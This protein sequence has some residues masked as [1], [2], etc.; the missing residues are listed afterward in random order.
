MSK[1]KKRKRGLKA[2]SLVSKLGLQMTPE[3]ALAIRVG[4]LRKPRVR[5][6]STTK[7]LLPLPEMT[8]QILL[9]QQGEFHHLVH[10]FALFRM[11]DGEL[12]M[13]SRK[14]VYPVYNSGEYLFVDVP[15][16]RVPKKDCSPLGPIA[17]SSERIR[18]ISSPSLLT[19]VEKLSEHADGPKLKKLALNIKNSPAAVA[20]KPRAA[21]SAMTYAARWLRQLNLSQNQ[22]ASDDVRKRALSQLAKIEEEIASLDDQFKW[23]STEAPTGSG[24][25]RSFDAPTDGILSL[26]GYQVGHASQLN[27]PTRYLILDR[28]FRMS[29]PPVL[30]GSHMALWGM[31][32]SSRRL[33]KIAETIAALVRNAKRR[34]NASYSRA[35]F[36]WESDLQQLHDTLYIGRFDFGWPSTEGPL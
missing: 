19:L 8:K 14:V 36:E 12:G 24:T 4:R 23:P 3:R 10:G 27:A 31:P 30:P 33:K 29:L 15:A 26:F 2:S 7:R 18:V 35:I 9:F 21:T 5:P 11:P 6:P 16:A 34:H 28:I 1:G 17:L 13:S 22:S 25:L 20:T 32:N